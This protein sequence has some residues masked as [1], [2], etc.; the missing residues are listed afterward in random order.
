M[1]K[2]FIHFFEVNNGDVDQV[3]NNF[4]GVEFKGREVR[5]EISG[6]GTSSSRSGGGERR[7]GGYQRREGGGGGYR[8]GNG[9]GGRR[10][11]GFN[12]DR[13]SGGGGNTGG[14]GFRDFS[15]KPR[16]ERPERRRRF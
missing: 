12:R 1:L 5:I 15:G 10:E 2:V 11:G 14:G 8:G 16:E 3:V 13:S 9:G 6:E 7:E 4:K